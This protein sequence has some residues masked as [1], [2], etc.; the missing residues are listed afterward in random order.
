MVCERAI[1]LWGLKLWNKP[2]FCLKLWYREERPYDIRDTR[3]HCFFLLRIN[4]QKVP[5]RLTRK[6]SLVNGSLVM[7]YTTSKMYCCHLLLWANHQ[8]RLHS[9]VCF[10]MLPPK[11]DFLIVLNRFEL[12]G[13]YS[14]EVRWSIL[15]AEHARVRFVPE[16]KTNPIL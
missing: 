2:C 15:R 6:S 1:V 5:S 14:A 16:G 11:I 3:T 7:I 10:R 13:M 9:Y 4:F 12:L 8:Q